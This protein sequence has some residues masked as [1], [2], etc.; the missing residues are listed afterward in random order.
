LRASTD[1][2][3]FSATWWVGAG[4]SGCTVAMFVV[5]FPMGLFLLMRSQQCDQLVR[6]HRDDVRHFLDVVPQNLWS[7]A[8][9]DTMAHITSE[10]QIHQKGRVSVLSGLAPMGMVWRARSYI[11]RVISTN[12]LITKRAGSKSILQLNGLAHPS[13]RAVERGRSP[14]SEAG[15]EGCDDPS[16]QY[17]GSDSG[18]LLDLDL[19][20]NTDVFRE[21]EPEQKHREDE[22]RVSMERRLP[23]KA[24]DAALRIG[25]SWLKN[26]A[27]NL[28]KRSILVSMG[29][30][31]R[32]SLMEFQNGERFRVLVLEMEDAGKETVRRRPVTRLYQT[33]SR[34]ALGQFF[35]PFKQE[36]YFWQCWEILR[37]VLQ[38]GFVLVVEMFTSAQFAMVYA[39]LIS[40]LALA[41]HTQFNPYMLPSMGMLQLLLL[42]SQFLIQMGIL[43]SEMIEHEGTQQAVGFFLLVF[44]TVILTAACFLIYP[45]FAPV[46]TILWAKCPPAVVVFHRVGS[47]LTVFSRKASAQS[48]L[49]GRPMDSETGTHSPAR[50]PAQT[51]CLQQEQQWTRNP[52]GPEMSVDIPAV[53]GSN[54][55]ELAHSS[56]DQILN[57][58]LSPADGLQWNEHSAGVTSQTQNRECQPMEMLQYETF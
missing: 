5:G 21:V 42:V 12:S 58:M 19:Y 9:E 34:V 28:M 46:A 7:A 16:A 41:L 20:I 18:N 55:L 53:E 29:E 39:V 44:Q 3:C 13:K 17:V 48:P 51:T 40:V 27:A 37:R 33:F 31:G 24:R 2:E 11:K 43:T 25:R 26:A 36:L 38:T 35:T 30:T 56:G 1:I 8:T 32:E 52:I 10:F 54:C 22:G 45:A 49:I 14:P 23:L 4:I 57:V 47:T 6:V 15:A 50:T